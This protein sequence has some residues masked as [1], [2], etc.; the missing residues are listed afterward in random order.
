[1]KPGVSR[2]LISELVL[3]DT[4]SDPLSGWMDLTMMS[5][6]GAERTKAHWTRLLEQS[7]FHMKKTY[8]APGTNYG[9]VE[10]YLNESWE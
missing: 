9:A 4:G 2:L 8:H 1:M 6:S 3:P 10:A 5:V 7:G